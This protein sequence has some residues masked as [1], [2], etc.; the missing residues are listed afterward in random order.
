MTLAWCAPKLAPTIAHIGGALILIAIGVLLLVLWDKFW[1]KDLGLKIFVAVVCFLLAIILIA[2][3]CFYTVERKFQGIFLEYAKSFL[4]ENPATFAYIPLF[5]I[6]AT[7]LVALIVWQHACFSS[8]SATSRNFFNFNNT[9]FWEV[10]NIL[11]FIWAFQF[12][13]DACTY[14]R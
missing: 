4:S 9:G 5:M 11:E 7:G 13:R 1:T 2:M 10:L 12:L 3:L 14:F 8:Q 6:L